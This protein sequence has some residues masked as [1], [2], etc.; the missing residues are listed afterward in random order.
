M[1]INATLPFDHTFAPQEFV[2][3]EAVTEISQL[4]ERVG[5]S[6]GNVTDHPCPTARWVDA[7]GHDA[8]DPFVMLSLVAAVTKTLRLQTGILVLPYRNPFIVARAAATLDVFS[9]G[10]LTLSF[11]AGYLKGEYFALGAD[12]ERRNETMD[13]YIQAMKAAWTGEE[14]NFE[15]TGYS[16]RGNRMRPSPIQKPHPPLYIGGNSKRAL[17]RVAEMAD[18]WNPFF[19]SEGVSSTARTTSMTSDLDLAEGIAYMR[20]HC[21]KIGRETLP[22]V[23]LASVTKPG[24]EWNAQAIIDKLGRF[25]EMGVIGAGAS[26]DGKTRAEWCDNAERFGTEVIQKLI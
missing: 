19:T 17:R 25:K 20:E 11:G 2:T 10:R 7:G 21:E 26:I 5:F 8:Q 24:E 15:G 6:G 18:G 23:F 9:N 4:V 13:E 3:M 1:K 22:D 16:A 14:F 12:F